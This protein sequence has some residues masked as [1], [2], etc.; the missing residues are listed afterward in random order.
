LLVVRGPLHGVVDSSRC[1]L[2]RRLRGVLLHFSFQFEEDGA[3]FGAVVGL[4]AT[5]HAV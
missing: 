5:K 1:Q 4:T 3:I 2:L